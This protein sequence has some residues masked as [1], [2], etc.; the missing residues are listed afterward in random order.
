PSNAPSNA[1]GNASGMPERCGTDAEPMQRREEKRREER[2]TSP[3]GDGQFDEW[4][5]AYPRKVGKGQAR[6]AYTAALKKTSHDQLVAAATKF[7]QKVHGSDPKFVAHP[8]TWL[9]GERWDDQDDTMPS[10]GR[11]VTDGDGVT[12]DL[13]EW[14]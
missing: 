14:A 7:T 3:A 4:W 5:K 12:W 11:T 1:R 6:R 9:N 8:A 10:I 2:T 13:G